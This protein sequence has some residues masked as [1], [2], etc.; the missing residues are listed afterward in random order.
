MKQLALIIGIAAGL[1]AVGNAQ[2][3]KQD[4][5]TAGQETKHAA[6]KTG[7]KVKHTAKATGHKVKHGTKHAVEKTTG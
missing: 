4:M 7:K 6:K 2:D 3:A 1:T 5:K